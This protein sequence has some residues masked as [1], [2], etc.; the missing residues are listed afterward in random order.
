MDVNTS[1]S[2]TSRR[3]RQASRRATNEFLGIVISCVGAYA[4]LI[5]IS[6]ALAS[7]TLGLFLLGGALLGGGLHIVLGPLQGKSIGRALLEVLAVG[8]VSFA[9]VYGCMW[10]FTVYLASRPGPIINLGA[11]TSTL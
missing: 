10:Y 2:T 5:G 6:P 9:L 4:M 3:K 1:M 7:G 8:A 11:P